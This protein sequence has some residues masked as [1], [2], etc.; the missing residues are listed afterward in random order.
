MDMT[1]EQRTIQAH[2]LEAIILDRISELWR[3]RAWY[4]ARPDWYAFMGLAMAN[5]AELRA[6]VRLARKARDLARPA[7]ESADA[8]TRAKTAETWPDH[9]AGMPS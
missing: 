4:R 5:T 2:A 7:V 1:S 3:W 9:F 6:L 8:V